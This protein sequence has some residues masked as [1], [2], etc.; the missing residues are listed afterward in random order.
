MVSG[1]VFNCLTNSPLPL[2]C[3]R[4]IEDICLVACVG[5]VVGLNVNGELL[6]KGTGVS[7][8]EESTK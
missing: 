4:H 7:E 3:C 5:F 6:N 2:L 8:G 1:L